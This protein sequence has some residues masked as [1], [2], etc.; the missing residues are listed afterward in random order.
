M[1]QIGHNVTGLSACGSN[2][3][4]LTPSGNENKLI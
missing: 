1:T 2:V 3:E 4:A